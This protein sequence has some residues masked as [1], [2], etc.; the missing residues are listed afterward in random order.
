MGRS[1]FGAALVLTACLSSGCSGG[2]GESSEP[3]GSS[4]QAIIDGT[5]STSAQDSVVL[6][7]QPLSAT[8]MVICSGVLLAPNLVMTARHC[9]SNLPDEAFTCDENGVGSA[10]GDIESDVD[11]SS[12]YV[13]V[14]ATRQTKLSQAAA[15]GKELFHDDATNICNHDVAVILLD[16]SI[17]DAV[18]APVRLDSGP[19]VNESIVAV[20]WGVTSTTETPGTRQ[21]RTI[22]V[23]RVGP[24]RDDADE[25]DVPPNEFEVGESICEGDS[26]G[27]AFDSTTG[28]VVGI[29]SRGGNGTTPVD[30]DPAAAC[31]N[32]SNF[33]SE[34]SHFEA[35]IDAAYT[36]AGA[37]PDLEVGSDGGT[38]TTSGGGGSSGGCAVSAA[39]AGGSRDS[40][41][42][43]LV[44]FGLAFAA[45][46]S[47]RTRRS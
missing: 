32:A 37:T 35:V 29:V 25:L 28:A 47:R 10:G 16:T 20:G 8:E 9:V 3:T 18:I 17:P 40:S 5:N 41:P 39:G 36:A 13:F 33:Y 11:P 43:G 27:P 4:S 14:G 23:Q 19:L 1:I 30:N 45:L 26:G 7:E 24:G 6:I 34:P 22:S 38:S 21:Q 2:A 42:A 15:R 31:V 44:V 46:I 12:L